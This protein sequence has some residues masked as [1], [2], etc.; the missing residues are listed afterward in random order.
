MEICT[1]EAPFTHIDG[2]TY[3]Q[4]NGIA[5]GSPLSCTMANFFM[6]HHENKVLENI[7]TK[8]AIYCRYVD[9]IF[10]CVDGKQQLLDLKTNMERETNLNFTYELSIDNKLP[11]LDVLVKSSNN[12]FETSVYVKE[13][14]SGECL[15]YESDAPEQYKISVITSFL[16]R[17][18]KV[19]SKKSSASDSS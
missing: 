11:F 10:V 7:Q 13:T 9:D 4:I 18:Y 3:R 1:K 19:S 12:I 17:A 16:N 2:N 5:M 8:P 15:K 6:C 14:N